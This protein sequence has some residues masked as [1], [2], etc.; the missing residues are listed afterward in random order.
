[1]YDKHFVG[2]DLTGFQDNGIQRPISRVTLKVD[3]EHVLTAGDDTGLEITADCPHA[4]QAMV[5]GLLAQLKGATYQMFSADDA[6]L[7]PAAELGDGITAGGVY[8]VISRIADDGSGYTGISAPG[9]AEM[10]DKY[11]AG[12]PM[13]Q[14]F[15]R[16]IAQTRSS[17]TKTAEQ[18]RLEVANEVAGMNSKIEQT[19]SSLDAKI[20]ATD[21]RVTSLSASLDG[22]AVR[23]ESAEGN[24][25]QLE[26]TA[27]GLSTSIGNTN[28]SLATLS[29]KVDGFTLS[30]TNGE[31]SSTIK[32][33]SGKTEVSSQNITMTGL[34]TLK[35]LSGGTTTIDG[36]CIKTGTI[37]A[38]RL[39]LTGAITFSDLDSSAQGTINGAVSNANSAL[40]AANS[41]QSTVN[42]W[43]YT[44]P[45]T[46]ELSTY[47]DGSKLMTGTVIAHTLEGKEINLNTEYNGK[48][49]TVGTI[50]LTSRFT[51]GAINDCLE[52]GS[53]DISIKAHGSID[54][55][56]PKDGTGILITNSGFMTATGEFHLNGDLYPA[57]GGIHSLGNNLLTW[58]DIYLA[59][60]PIITS[61]R[62]K[63]EA[64]SYSLDPYSAL[65]DAL[66]PASFRYTD[67]Q[68]GRTHLGMISQDVEQAL[69]A[70]GISSTDF[71]G[72]IKSPREDGGSDYAL[73]YGEF[74]ALLIYEMQQMKKELKTLKEERI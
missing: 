60:S 20:S 22:I 40:T 54:L 27:N 11:P 12:G 4:T 24:I 58:K 70:C 69:E 17:I 15:N 35:G 44:D 51:Q 14:E 10:E 59:Q 3:D 25:G 2:L 8:S 38:E 72:F 19:A 18:I 68:S 62:A 9:E 56:C 42:G 33:M 34:V 73:R 28:S 50:S 63:K 39:N 46:G 37:S 32:L 67:G 7:N 5:N 16:K 74:I 41:A 21:G 48:V 52:I 53:G 47:I 30:V 6:N 55:R 43:A 57:G 71:A 49:F 64:I 36:A 45:E 1:L 65:F 26:R 61:D 29:Q 31:T 66:R 23:V 13:T